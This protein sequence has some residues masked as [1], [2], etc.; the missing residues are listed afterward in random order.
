MCVFFLLIANAW[1]MESALEHKTPTVVETVELYK[2]FYFY[3]YFYDAARSD[4]K[5][6]TDQ[7]ENSNNN[8]ENKKL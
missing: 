1:E 4:N 3:F 2:Y 7:P 8:N 5:K 6:K